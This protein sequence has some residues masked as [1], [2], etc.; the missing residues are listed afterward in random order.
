M[1][2]RVLLIALTAAAS[3]FLVSCESAVDPVSGEERPFTLWGVLN[4]AADTQVVRVFSV[5]ES[6]DIYLGDIDARV[7]SQNLT[8]S[9][10]REWVYRRIEYSEGRLGHAFW[11]PFRPQVG[12]TYKLTVVRSDGARS[13]A[14]VQVPLGVEVD[15]DV[16]PTRTEVPVLITGDANI[17]GVGVRYD[18]SNWPPLDAPEGVPLYPPLRHAVDVSYHGMGSPV[19]GGR[20]YTI[21]MTED[22]KA[23]R[24]EYERNCL[25]TQASPGIALRGVEFHFAA[26]N[27]EWSPPGGDFDPE[28]LIQPGL[29]SNVDNGYGF[30][31]AGQV[32]RVRWVPSR[33]VISALGFVIGQRDNFSSD[34]PEP[35][36]GI[37]LATIWDLWR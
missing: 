6:P 5:G 26:V 16:D 3:L 7:F 24:S 1:L 14:T 29:F 28:L 31:G 30:I 37:N 33:A 23:V 10:R 27:K 35:C 18:A 32:V 2:V 4:S 25:V 36:L 9:E 21:R 13:S 22:V 12:E 15:V 8:T 11:S 17:I 20:R 19:P 34:P